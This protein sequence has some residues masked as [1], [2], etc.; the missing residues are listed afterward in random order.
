[1]ET[2]KKIGCFLGS[3][4]AVIGCIGGIGYA[5]HI[6]EPVIAI[7]IGVL[8]VAAVPTVIKWIKNLVP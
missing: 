6:G 4:L 7:A 5:C 8:S 3:F 2:I 1:M